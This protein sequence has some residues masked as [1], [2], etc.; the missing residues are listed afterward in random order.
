VVVAKDSGKFININAHHQPWKT[1]RMYFCLI[2]AT[3]MFKL[4]NT[5]VSECVLPIEKFDKDIFA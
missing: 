3:N 4:H 2:V 1:G 5:K